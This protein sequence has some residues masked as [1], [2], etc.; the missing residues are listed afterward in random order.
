MI[1]GVLLLSSASKQQHAADQQT[2]PDASE[3][4]D[5]PEVSEVSDAP[6]VSDALNA[7]DASDVAAFPSGDVEA[8]VVPHLR[9]CQGAVDRHAETR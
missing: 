6:E 5:A 8:A 7:L 3:A 9:A 1:C 4:L 2:L